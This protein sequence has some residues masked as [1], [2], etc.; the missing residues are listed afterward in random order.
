VKAVENIHLLSRPLI[1]KIF[2][3]LFSASVMADNYVGLYEKICGR[4]KKVFTLP[5]LPIPLKKNKYIV[6][7]S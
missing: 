1:R 7:T 6:M 3:H 5:S 4:K 2:K